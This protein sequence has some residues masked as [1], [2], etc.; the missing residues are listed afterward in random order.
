MRPVRNV[1]QKLSR[2]EQRREGVVAYLWG[3]PSPQAQQLS[4]KS[5]ARL[6]RR[7]GI[8]V[9]FQNIFPLRTPTF[10]NIA[11]KFAQAILFKYCLEVKRTPSDGTNSTS[12]TQEKKE[13]TC[14]QCCESGS[15]GYVIR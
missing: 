6:W 2:T 9:S 4:D 1:F 12:N 10:F 3:G 8:M 11:E 14:R 5:Q 7:A 15:G 13:V